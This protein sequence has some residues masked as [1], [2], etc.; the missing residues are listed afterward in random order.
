MNHLNEYAYIALIIVLLFFCIAAVVAF[1]HYFVKYFL[2]KLIHKAFGK[3][4]GMGKILYKN[5]VFHRIAYL[6]PAFILYHFAYLFNFDSKYAK[7]YFAD[8]VT[9]VTTIYIF[10]GTAL[11]FSA[12][13]NCVNDK[14]RH[15]AI[16][17][18]KPIK[19]YL[20]VV[21]LIIYIVTGV[22]IA[23]VL[24]DKSPAYFFTGVGAATAILVLVFKDSI[25]GFVASI[26]LAAYDMV[27]IGDWIEMQSF[28][29]DGEVIDISLNTVKVQNFDK[30]FVTIPSYALLTSGIKN[31]RGMQEAGGRRVKQAIYLD[32]TSIKRCDKKLLEQLI[33]IDLLSEGLKSSLKTKDITNVGALRSY[34]EVY[35]RKHTGVH[36]DMRIMVRQQQGTSTGLPIELCFFTNEIDSSKHEA[37]QADIFDHI[38]AVLVDFDLRA[39][40]LQ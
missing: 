35:V 17:K 11:L 21:K 29:A 30:T 31:W 33:D 7:I 36:K 34:L 4:S 18:Q 40:Q 32:I 5:H 3:R 38:Y 22:F 24:F 12:I 26:Q 16:S 2:L 9:L 39:F 15:L 14:Y 10:I 8:L 13:L 19:S 23:S 20:Q 28:G 1:S 37:I 25:M 27:R 6:I